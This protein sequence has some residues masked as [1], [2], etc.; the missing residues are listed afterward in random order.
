MATNDKAVSRRKANTAAVGK[1]SK[2]IQAIADTKKTAKIVDAD[3]KITKKVIKQMR[4]GLRPETMSN[5]RA[6]I[7]G[8][9][10]A[11]AFGIKN[12]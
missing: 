2:K 8:A 5:R 3:P 12:K 11:G 4:K 1:A 10:I 7:G 6:R 9:G